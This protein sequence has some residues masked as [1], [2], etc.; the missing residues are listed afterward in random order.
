M[1]HVLAPAFVANFERT[2]VQARA[3]IATAPE[4]GELFGADVDDDGIAV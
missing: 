3:L 4:Q 2:Q 1:R